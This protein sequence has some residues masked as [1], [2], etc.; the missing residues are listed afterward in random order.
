MKRTSWLILGSVSLTLMTI[1]STVLWQER[2]RQRYYD[3]VAV[4]QVPEF[5][6]ISIGET[7]VR[8]ELADTTSKRA[9]GLSGRSHL[10]SGEGMLFVFEQ[11]GMYGFWMPD[12]YFALDMI[13]LD[14]D[15]VVIS[16]TEN[17]TPESYP[18]QFYPARPAQFVLEVPAF[19]AAEHSIVPGLQAELT[20]LPEGGVSAV[21]AL[22]TYSECCIL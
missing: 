19:F 12:M 4:I 2:P 10:A 6:T 9:Q 22:P 15:L 1:G 3:D 5:L 21:K 7:T 13:W 17:A 14:H 8:A 16:V 20:D 11:P 18:T